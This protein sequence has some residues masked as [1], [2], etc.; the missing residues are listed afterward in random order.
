MLLTE[1]KRNAAEHDAP[2]LQANS[3]S[4]MRWERWLL[5]HGVGTHGIRVVATGDG[6]GSLGPA[7]GLDDECDDVAGTEHDG[8]CACTRQQAGEV[9]EEREGL[10]HIALRRLY[11]CPRRLMICPRITKFAAMRGVGAIMVVVILKNGE[12]VRRVEQVEENTDCMR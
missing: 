7:G 4:G 3:G 11:C 5:H 8:I 10:H 6:S 1:L 12:R 2:A 9:A